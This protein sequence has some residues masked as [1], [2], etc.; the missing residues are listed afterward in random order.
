MEMPSA[1]MIEGQSARH[2]NEAGQTWSAL[3]NLMN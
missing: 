2:L 1:L 3:K